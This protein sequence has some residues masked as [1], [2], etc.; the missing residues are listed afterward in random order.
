[1][2]SYCTSDLLKLGLHETRQASVH[3]RY[4]IVALYECRPTFRDSVG[5]LFA[6][7]Q[8]PMSSFFTA[9]STLKHETTT[10]SRQV[11]HKPPSQR[12]NMPAQRTPRLN[13]CK[14]LR[15]Y[16]YMPVHIHVCSFQFYGN[17]LT[18]ISMAMMQNFEVIS[19]KVKACKICASVIV[20]SIIIKKGQGCPCKRHDAI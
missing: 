12:S 4:C 2:T 17:Q 7:V 1:M 9:Q 14:S 10:L 5:V 13:R 15:M 11:G 19:D 16:I 6:T 3:L 18:I 20:S 8:C